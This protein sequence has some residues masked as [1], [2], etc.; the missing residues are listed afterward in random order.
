MLY[1]IQ[2]LRCHLARLVAKITSYYLYGY[3]C[4]LEDL[5]CR[6]NQTEAYIRILENLESC[7]LNSIITSNIDMFINSLQN[8]AYLKPCTNC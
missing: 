7:F 8:E 6:L 3:D 1:N 4:N 2:V 5:E